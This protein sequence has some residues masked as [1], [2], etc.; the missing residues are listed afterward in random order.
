MNQKG[1]GV[2]DEVKSD[3]DGYPSISLISWVVGFQCFYFDME[4][5][6]HHGK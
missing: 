2:P 5:Q 1:M 6:D 3:H 4:N